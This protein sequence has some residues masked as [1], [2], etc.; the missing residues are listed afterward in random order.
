MPIALRC[1]NPACDKAARLADSYR[2][3]WV[4]CPACGHQFQ[5]ASETLAPG[6]VITQERPLADTLPTT[7]PSHK[8]VASS[9]VGLPDHIGRFLIKEK[10]GAGAF[11]AVYRAHDPQLG[12][13]VALKVPHPGSLAEPHLAERFLR[14]GRAAAGLHHPHIVPVFDAGQDGPHHYLAAAFIQGRSLAHE[15]ADGP[16]DCRR[17][18][19]VVRQLAEALAYAHARGIVH[20]D[21]KPANVLLDQQGETHLADFGLAHRADEAGELTREG[22]VLGTPAYMAPEQ[23]EGHKGKPLPAS[24]QYSLGAVLYELLTG[25]APHSGPPAIVLYNLLHQ[26]PEPLRQRNPQ[27][28][29]ELEAVC[30]KALAKRP[31]QRYANCAELAADLRR[32]LEGE[33]VAARPLGVAGRCLRWLKREPML[34]GLATLTVVC[35]LATSLLA[36]GQAREQAALQ[37]RTAELVAEAAEKRREAAEQS[38]QAEEQESRAARAAQKA[39]EA[40]NAAAR[41]RTAMRAAA[42]RQRQAAARIQ[43]AGRQAIEQDRQARQLLY[44]AHL[45]ITRQALARGDLARARALLDRYRPES[46]RQDLQSADWLRLRKRLAADQLVQEHL[47]RFPCLALSPD[48]TMIASVSGR[49]LRLSRRNAV[50]MTQEAFSLK[51]KETRAVCFSP[52]GKHLATISKDRSEYASVMVWDARTGRLERALTGRQHVV[53]VSYSSNSKHLVTGNTSRIVELWEPQTGRQLLS[54]KGHS[55]QIFTVAFRP[56]GQRFVSASGAYDAKTQKRWGDIRVWDAQTGQQ[57]LSLK[58]DA[59]ETVKSVVFSPDGKRLVAGSSVYDAK[60]QK[61]WGDIRVWDAQTGQ[62]TLSLPVRTAGGLGSVV[63][64][65]DGNHL[66]SVFDKEVKIWDVRTGKELH[67]FKGEYGALAFSPDGKR[68]ASR[69]QDYN[70]KRWEWTVKVWDAQTGEQLLTLAQSTDNFYGMTFSA[71]GNQFAVVCGDK[72]VRVWKLPPGRMRQLVTALEQQFVPDQAAPV[73][74]AAFSS[75]GALASAGPDR[76]VRLGYPASGRQY[77]LRG[78]LATAVTA[79]A[80]SADDKLLAGAAPDGSVTLWEA[81]A[82]RKRLHFDGE[83]GICRAICFSR[84]GKLLAAA[85]GKSLRVWDVASGKRRLLLAGFTG[86]VTCLAFRADG[87]VVAGGSE[88]GIVRLWDAA[89]GKELAVLDRHPGSVHALVFTP[90]GQTLATGSTD[91]QARLWDPADGKLIRTLKTRADDVR[92]LVF[93]RNDHVLTA[94]GSDGTLTRWWVP[95]SPRPEKDR[96]L[97]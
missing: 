9:P 21:V 23:A 17:A 76:R 10:L 27:I 33:P 75:Q 58:V 80:F 57:T 24:D 12:R 53:S 37:E 22:A 92:V 81:Y 4:R 71:D 52:D 44:D 86:T 40:R 66:F 77:G 56:D 18:A 78:D 5:V 60:T 3:R 35:L 42:D 90:D 68:L 16:L 30:L 32:W 67:S 97:P 82:V 49:R 29:P 13:E 36:L 34:A 65:P 72:P 7:P 48:G 55:G 51:L 50:L 62:Q 70:G 54:C 84:D 2:G 15:V 93:G 88:D 47:A 38:K 64:S 91:N 28:P 8:R 41:Q 95:V 69:S 31:E 43:E 61:R 26:E 6:A 46:S 45:A 83:P 63:F 39:T 19:E 11:G 59:A 94:A 87:K 20:R 85:R 74:A 25:E 14:E 73:T 1:P 89:T 96:G 79:L